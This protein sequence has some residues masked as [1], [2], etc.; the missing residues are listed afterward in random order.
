MGIGTGSMW[1]RRAVF[2]AGAVSAAA[3][4]CGVAVSLY[5]LIAE[6]CLDATEG[7][8]DA[9]PW[10]GPIFLASALGVPAGIREM[11]GSGVCGPPDACSLF[12]ACCYRCSFV[13]LGDLL[14]LAPAYQLPALRFAVPA[15]TSR[16]CASAH[17]PLMCTC[18]LHMLCQPC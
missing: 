14:T 2:V 11:T 7:C 1:L 5:M 8:L 6:G 12:L 17:N 3:S 13:V 4:L 18:M 9:L 16:E 10:A 15:P